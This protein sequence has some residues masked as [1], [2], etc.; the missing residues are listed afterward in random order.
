[1]IQNITTQME[2]YIRRQTIAN[3]HSNGYASYPE[4]FVPQADEIWISKYE[5]EQN[6]L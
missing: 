5:E 3:R 6:A 1:M 2:P 4:S